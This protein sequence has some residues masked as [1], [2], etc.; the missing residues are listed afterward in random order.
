MS[1]L[2]PLTSSSSSPTPWTGLSMA[3]LV[4][5]FTI[6]A[7]SNMS[8]IEIGNQKVQTVVPSVPSVYKDVYKQ[9]MK[10]SQNDNIKTI[11]D[12][13]TAFSLKSSAFN[14]NGYFPGE[15]TCLDG[16]TGGVSPQLYWVYP[17]V[18]SEQFMIVMWSHHTGYTCDRYE[19]VVYDIPTTFTSIK[20]GNPNEIGTMGGTYPGS[21]KFTYSPPCANGDGN[22]TYEFTIYSLR[23][24]IKPYIESSDLSDDIKYTG[25][26]L[27]KVRTLT[28]HD[29]FPLSIRSF[30]IKLIIATSTTTLVLL[31][32]IPNPTLNV[33]LTQPSYL[34]KTIHHQVALD[35]KL[36][37]DTAT[38]SV[39][40]NSIRGP[41]PPIN[42]SPPTPSPLPYGPIDPPVGRS[43]LSPLHTTPHLLPYI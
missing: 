24:D 31:Q 33:S 17:P 21:P 1:S 27:V 43:P 37:V 19:W 8:N 5:L 12:T 7:L 4:C 9:L 34:N 41:P 16:A 28:L 3:L 39:Q 26:Y 20:A 14:E 11:S 15:Y 35:N 30:I 13:G 25:P 38:I 6:M 40:F 29:L 42:G 10:G 22:K 2:Q 36:I 18:E 23:T 32:P